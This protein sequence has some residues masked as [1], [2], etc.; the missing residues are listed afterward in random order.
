MGF[1][2]KAYILSHSTSPFLWWVFFFKIGSHKLFAL[3]GF[4]PQPSRSASWVAR[5]TGMSHQHPAV[6]GI[7]EIGSL[8]LSAQANFEPP[9]SW[10]LSPK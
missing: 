7:F 5:I 8:E 6:L 10:F 2:L 9:S 3:A 1:E 4:E